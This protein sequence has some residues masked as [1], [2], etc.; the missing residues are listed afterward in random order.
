LGLTRGMAWLPIGRTR[1]KATNPEL[2]E[3]ALKTSSLG[4]LL[5]PDKGVVWLPISRTR[6]KSTYPELTELA[7]KTSSLELNMGGGLASYWSYKK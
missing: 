6:N 5:E 3:L 2:T 4:D 7:L 1:N